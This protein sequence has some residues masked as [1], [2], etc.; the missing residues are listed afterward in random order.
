[1]P[2]PRPRNTL[3]SG[4]GVA[5]AVLAAVV[6]TFALVSGIV[7]YNV[8]SVDQ[9]PRS[10][11]ALVLGALRADS[12]SATPLVLGRPHAPATQRRP[13]P[14][15]PDARPAL[16]RA[17]TR[18]PAVT[19]LSPPGERA[20]DP[21][22]EPQQHAGDG[23]GGGAP[24]SVQPAPDRPLEPVG[25]AI[26]A[27]GEAVGATTESLTRRIDT[28]AVTAGAAVAATRDVLRTTADRTGRAVG[29]LLGGSPPR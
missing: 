9:L 24:P 16:A 29:G 11:D 4:V 27:T 5:G 25:D 13:A 26:G 22:S 23:D 14:A 21:K 28:V 19:A 7:A 3:I 12:E 1:M 20:S 15:A 17:G 10:S 18:A 6:A 8:T 2:F